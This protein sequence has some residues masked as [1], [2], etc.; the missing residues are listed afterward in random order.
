MGAT[1]SRVGDHD[2]AAQ[3]AP[4]GMTDRHI[5]TQSVHYMTI[6]ATAALQSLTSIS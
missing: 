1:N 5:D 3:K 6:S 2:R 4:E